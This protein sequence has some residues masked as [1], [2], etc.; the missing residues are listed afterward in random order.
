MHKFLTKFAQM[1]NFL[2][3]FASEFLTIALKILTMFWNSQYHWAGASVTG[4]GA[5]DNMDITK[6]LPCLGEQPCQRAD[7]ENFEK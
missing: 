4:A 3:I 6:L 5:P 2:T 1:P 7:S